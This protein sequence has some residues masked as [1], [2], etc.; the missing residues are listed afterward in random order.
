MIGA[1]LNILDNGGSVDLDHDILKHLDYAI[2]SMHPQTFKPSTA[3]DNTAAY[4]RSMKHPNVKILG[5]CDDSRFPVD[6]DALVKAAPDTAT[7]SSCQATAM[8]QNISEILAWRL[9]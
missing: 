9:L 6:Y 2:V 8:G 4:I 5:H 1:E 3:A 7:P